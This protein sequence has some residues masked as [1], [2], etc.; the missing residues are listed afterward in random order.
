MRLTAGSSVNQKY[1]ESYQ[2]D[3]HSEET[4][5]LLSLSCDCSL[6]VLFFPPLEIS[7]L[8]GSVGDC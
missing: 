1:R 6:K 7:C 5:A 2:G 4:G 3:W 8:A